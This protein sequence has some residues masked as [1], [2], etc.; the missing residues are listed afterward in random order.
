MT[1]TVRTALIAL[2]G[3]AVFLAWGY[4]SPALAEEGGLD[5]AAVSDS[6]LDNER[7]QGVGEDFQLEA[8]LNGGEVTVDGAEMVNEIADGAFAG[9]SGIIT[10]IQNNGNQAIIQN[11]VAININVYPDAPQ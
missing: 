11:G 4:P 10:V 1:R 8:T 6:D 9:S 7:A 5:W 2:G 3:L